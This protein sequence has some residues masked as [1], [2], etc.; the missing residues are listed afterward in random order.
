MALV[1]LFGDTGKVLALILLILQLSSAGA[2]MPIEL[3]GGFF[4]WLHPLLPFT[5]VVRAFRAA[6][7]DAFNGAWLSAWLT[8]IGFG[9]GAMLLAA[10]AGR[11]K[12]VPDAEYRPAMDV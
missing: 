8:I 3:A 10:F 6:L 2:V 9:V 1:R 4:R 7:F 5:W 12:P 11:W